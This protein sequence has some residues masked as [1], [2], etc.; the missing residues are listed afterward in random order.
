MDGID[1]LAAGRRTGS[2]R[3]EGIGAEQLTSVLRSATRSH[4]LTVVDLPRWSGPSGQETLRRASA[5]LLLVRADLRGVAAAREVVP[6]LP[7]HDCLVLLRRRRSGTVAA[8]L[9]EQSL[10]LPV[11]ATA[12]DETSVQLAAERGEPPSRSARSGLARACS[13]VLDQ[14]PARTVPA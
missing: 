7:E 9:V 3:T 1:L 8:E 14:L 4:D 6:W 11:V 13:A 12:A 2:R 10:G 5:T